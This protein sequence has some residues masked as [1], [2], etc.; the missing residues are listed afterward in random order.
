MIL[1][2]LFHYALIPSLLFAAEAAKPAKAAASPGK[3]R[4]A[5]VRS[6]EGIHAIFESNPTSSTLQHNSTSFDR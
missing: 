6:E 1:Y 5:P 3:G 4:K 2:T